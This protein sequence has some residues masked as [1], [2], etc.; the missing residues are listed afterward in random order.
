[1][2]T[3]RWTF[4]AAMTSRWCVSEY[5]N[6]Q[7]FVTNKRFFGEAAAQGPQTVEVRGRAL[8]G[9]RDSAAIIDTFVRVRR[10]YPKQLSEHTYGILRRGLVGA[11]NR[12]QARAQRDGSPES[13][14]DETRARGGQSATLHRWRTEPKTLWYQLR[15]AKTRRQRAAHSRLGRWRSGT[16]ADSI[17]GRLSAHTLRFRGLNGLG[18]APT[19]GDQ[20]RMV[21]RTA[22]NLDAAMAVSVRDTRSLQQ[23]TGRNAVCCRFTGW[24]PSCAIFPAMT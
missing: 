16:G 17:V 2:T 19:C 11:R 23:G 24:R 20:E 10:R 4:S 9:L 1:M 13:C 7:F 21:R 12:Q 8:S 3:G 5:E 14:R 18:R 15:L 6:G 22:G